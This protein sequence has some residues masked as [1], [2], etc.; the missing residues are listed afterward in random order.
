MTNEILIWA[1]ISQIAFYH[2]LHRIDSVL[3]IVH[4]FG[5]HE[6]ERAEYA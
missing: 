5:W 3:G 1:M 6:M 4:I 2:G